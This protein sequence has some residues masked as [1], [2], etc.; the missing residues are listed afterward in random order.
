MIIFGLNFLFNI[1]WSVLFF[2]MK[3]P[4]LSFFELI[5]LL[6]PSIFAM[7]FVSWKIK[8][9]SAYLLIPY[10]IWVSFA[11]ILNYLIAF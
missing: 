6:W 7:V 8:K 5:F 4:I 1:L 11:G 9:L 2:T 3:N 10:L